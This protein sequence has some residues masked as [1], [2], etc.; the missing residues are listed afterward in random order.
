MKTTWIDEGRIGKAKVY[1][2]R[3]AVL[4]LIRR[5]LRGV[6]R[7][8]LIFLEGKDVDEI[9]D[10]RLFELGALHYGVTEQ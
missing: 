6:C 7:E 9:S 10:D 4:N 5:I 8:D 2:S 1:K 3:G